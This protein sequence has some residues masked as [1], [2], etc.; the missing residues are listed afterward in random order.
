LNK[1]A[2]VKGYVP[3]WTGLTGPSSRRSSLKHSVGS[4][5]G[6]HLA[7]GLYLLSLG[8]GVCRYEVDPKVTERGGGYA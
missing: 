8:E 5:L 3:Y 6:K 4:S 2:L 7:V 1:Q